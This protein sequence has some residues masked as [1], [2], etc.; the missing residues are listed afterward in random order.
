M[1]QFDDMFC[2]TAIEIFAD[3]GSYRVLCD[4]WCFAVDFHGFMYRMQFF[5]QNFGMMPVRWCKPTGHSTCV[6]SHSHSCVRIFP[7][8][9]ENTLHHA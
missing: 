6:Y 1:C 9:I 5:A 3:W 8:A 7:N 2:E 4:L